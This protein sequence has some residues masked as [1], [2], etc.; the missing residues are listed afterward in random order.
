MPVLA[1]RIDKGD[2][3]ENKDLMKPNRIRLE[4]Q[5]GYRAYRREKR[6]TD[7]EFERACKDTEFKE[8]SK[9]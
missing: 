9:R 3:F 4:N 2:T 5:T 8:Q 1:Q 7:E 6:T